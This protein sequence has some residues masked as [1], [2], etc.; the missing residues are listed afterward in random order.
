MSKKVVMWIDEYIDENTEIATAKDAEDGKLLSCGVHAV[1]AAFPECDLRTCQ[2]VE[3]FTG[4]LIDYV[5]YK[6]KI[7]LGERWPDGQLVAVV[8]DIMIE[9]SPENHYQDAYFLLPVVDEKSQIPFEANGLVKEYRK[10]RSKPFDL[11]M[12]LATHYMRNIASLRDIP[13]FFV[14]NRVLTSE[15]RSQ[16]SDFNYLADFKENSFPKSDVG[17]KLIEVLRQCM[18]A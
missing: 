17:N 15:L 18:S 2:T 1:R 12:D 7:S 8:I 16:L 4:A 5:R 14:T 11:G 6:E 13:I 10:V 9:A 3:Q